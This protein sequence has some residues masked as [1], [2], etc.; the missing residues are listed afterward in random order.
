MAI[1]DAIVSGAYVGE[2][3]TITVNTTASTVA[4]DASAVTKALFVLAGG[5]SR[6]EKRINAGI[7]LTDA[8]TITIVISAE[9]TRNLAPGN[10]PIELRVIDQ[11]GVEGVLLATSLP[12]SDSR[13][14]GI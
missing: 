4:I 8:N 1:V 13:T 10:Y 3:L 6:I 7:T 5:R 9:D 12:L 2:K 11:N 14:K